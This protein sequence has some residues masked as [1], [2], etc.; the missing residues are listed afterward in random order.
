MAKKLDNIVTKLSAISDQLAAGQGTAGRLLQDP[1]LYDSADQALV[2][3]RNLTKAIRENPK[4][5]LTIHF[6]VF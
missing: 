6:R 4:K 2:E 5:Y 3:L 1:K